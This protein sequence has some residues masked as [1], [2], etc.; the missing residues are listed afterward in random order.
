MA[1]APSISSVFEFLRA[2][3]VAASA[4]LAAVLRSV[5]AAPSIPSSAMPLLPSKST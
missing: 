1:P 5:I 3:Y 2:R 4:E